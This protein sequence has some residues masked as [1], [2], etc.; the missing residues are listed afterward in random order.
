MELISPVF[1]SGSAIPRQYSCRGANVNPPLNILDSPNIAQSLVLIMHE[2]DAL[3][4]DYVNWLVWDMPASTEL[5]AVN[6]LPVGAFQ[7]KNSAGF[8]AYAGPCPQ[9][10]SGTHRYFFDLYALDCS[11]GVA[12]GNSR[13]Q[14]ESAMSGHIIDQCSLVGTFT[15][16]N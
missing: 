12:A 9:P 1:R 4:G 5:I 10:G 2:P 6:S 8:S 7:G 13:E 14:L 3:K 16:H 11:L 15:S